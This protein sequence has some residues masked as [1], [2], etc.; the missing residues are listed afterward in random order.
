MAEPFY[1]YHIKYHYVFPGGGKSGTYD[2][3]VCYVKITKDRK[4]FS[5]Y[6]SAKK[7]VKLLKKRKT[8][9][10]TKKQ[11]ESIKH[12]KKPGGKRVNQ[13]KVTYWKRV[14][15]TTRATKKP[16]PKAP[17][18]KAKPKGDACAGTMIIVVTAAIIILSYLT[19]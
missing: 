12:A 10:A 13:P 9:P 5:H 19:I 14:K 8:Y 16:K 4:V 3:H 11:Y 1:L 2:R 6:S 7:A 15:P 17:P 18:K